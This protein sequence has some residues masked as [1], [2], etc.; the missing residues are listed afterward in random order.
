MKKYIKRLSV[1]SFQIFF[2]LLF[3]VGLAFA[4][5]TRALA[6][7]VITISVPG[8]IAPY[9][10]CEQTSDS[11]IH[12]HYQFVC[13]ERNYSFSFC[14]FEN[15]LTI[16]NPG[17][18]PLYVT[19]I[20]TIQPAGGQVDLG[21]NTP[22][23]YDTID[24]RATYSEGVY[25]NFWHVFNTSNVGTTT[26]DLYFSVDGYY[27]PPTYGCSDGFVPSGAV[28]TDAPILP[29]LETPLGPQGTPADEQ[30][31]VLEM[32]QY[33]RINARGKWSDGSAT[34]TN[35]FAYSTD[36]ET[37]IPMSELQSES[38]CSDSNGIIILATAPMFMI[39]V[40]D[41]AGNFADNSEPDPTNFPLL[42]S[43]DLVTPIGA[44]D[45]AQQFSLSESAMSSGVIDPKTADVVAQYSGS[46]ALFTPGT[47][48]AIVTDGGPYYNGQ[49]PDPQ[50]GVDLQLQVQGWVSALPG[51]GVT[52]I[53]CVTQD[54]NNVTI[55][56]QSDAMLLHLRV[57][58]GDANWGNNS[59]A[60]I[61]Y[62]I[63]QAVMV[64]RYM[65]PCESLYDLGST[66]GTGT[67]EA[68]QEGGVD[69]PELIDAANKPV[70]VGAN[71]TGRSF[72]VDITK[73][74]WVDNPAIGELTPP[75]SSYAADLAFRQTMPNTSP[76]WDYANPGTASYRCVAQLDEY[77]YRVYLPSQSA[78]T[79]DESPTYSFKFRVHDQDTPSQYYDNNGQLGWTSY[80]AN[81]YGDVIPDDGPTDPNACDAYTLPDTPGGQATVQANVSTGALFPFVPSAGTVMAIQTSGGPWT[82][83][84]G[85]SKYDI[86]IS[87]DNGSTWTPLWK[88]A[89]ARCAN[90]TETNYMTVYM[91]ALSYRTYKFRVNDGN[92]NFSDNTGDISISV[93]AMTGAGDGDGIL[94]P[95]P[96]TTCADNY[97]MAPITGTGLTPAV[98]KSVTTVFSL[99]S[100][101]GSVNNWMMPGLIDWN[102]L[103][104]GNWGSFLT[105]WTEAVREI[106]GNSSTGMGIVPIVQPGKLYALQTIG[107]PYYEIANPGSMDKK[108]AVQI[109][110]D[111]GSTWSDLPAWEGASCV[112]QKNQYTLVVFTADPSWDMRLRTVDSGGEVYS[113]LDNSGKMN[114]V[115]YTVT[116]TV[117]NPPPPPGG[118][119]TGTIEALCNGN[120]TVPTA[121]IYSVN[122]PS[123]S[124]GFGETDIISIPSIGFSIPDP[125]QW[126][127]YINCR[128]LQFF[129]WCPQHTQAVMA[130]VGQITQYE[131]F[132]TFADVAGLILYGMDEIT[133]YNWPAPFAVGGAGD[134]FT[135]LAKQSNDSG[136]QLSFTRPV[137]EPVYIDGLGGGSQPWTVTVCGN[138]L[139]NM[140][141]SNILTA[142]FVSGACW[143]Q[144][145]LMTPEALPLAVSVNVLYL[146]G[147]VVMLGMYFDKAYS[148]AR[149]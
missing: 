69:M 59:G 147:T 119:G 105:F 117:I 51:Q 64:N 116:Q 115:M 126:L 131:P 91:E 84:G 7:P 70:D 140:L 50:Y 111:N 57:T 42:W 34:K 75:V 101:V 110:T 36:G 123:F 95:P 55:Y 24:F 89:G 30:I 33:Y 124:F 12:C 97:L 114:F 133:S 2:V 113:W 19:F 47:Y 21:R 80:Q 31:A 27:Y 58:D 127:R 71:E 29:T 62:S 40:N 136:G 137:N 3:S 18:L 41:T 86:Q 46:S 87:D 23:I 61:T 11:E 35:D 22:I 63:Y 37:W 93:Y 44:F 121:S 135:M 148:S 76:P 60:P 138:S 125:G 67:V 104:G 88:Y 108:Y 26:Y 134:V 54:G 129:T 100:A 78:S 9:E 73:G 32:G 94:P 145:Q 120:C 8:Y 53:S 74:P 112:M 45:C 85:P 109:S 77:H 90:V 68:I 132:A 56:W 102:F 146:M 99:L 43:I 52:G 17:S 81:Y 128:I 83:N 96:W 122:T 103:V 144:V 79:Q 130:I 149:R 92:N 48:Y 20:G 72:V 6:S 1:Q 25:S 98:Q 5:P 15:N 82:D 66:L 143:A 141:G 106:P 49:S 28:I 142:R 65:D 4:I 38:A 39:R 13:T 118:D 107:G 16:T 10:T 14:R 139:V